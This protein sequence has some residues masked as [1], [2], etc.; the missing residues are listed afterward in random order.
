[1]LVKMKQ[2]KNFFIDFSTQFLHF[3][4]RKLSKKQKKLGQHLNAEICQR[5]RTKR[6]KRLD[7]KKHNRSKCLIPFGKSCIKSTVAERIENQRSVECFIPTFNIAWGEM[8]DSNTIQIN[9]FT[10]SNVF[11]APC[12]A[13]SFCCLP[14]IMNYLFLLLGCFSSNKIKTCVFRYGIGWCTHTDAFGKWCSCT[15]EQ[16]I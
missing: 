4:G 1:M 12:T 8:K 15:D 7:K 9:M 3:F 14:I 11:L 13:L 16:M 6:K 10:N 5:N 2:K